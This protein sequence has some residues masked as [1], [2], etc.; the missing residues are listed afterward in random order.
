MSA[1]GRVVTEETS[2][3]NLLAIQEHQCTQKEY[4]RDYLVYSRIPKFPHEWIGK[5]LSKGIQVRG[6]VLSNTVFDL[7]PWLEYS[8]VSLGRHPSVLLERLGRT[9]NY[10]LKFPFGSRSVRVGRP[11]G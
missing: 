9:G 6:L 8:R 2:I 5:L 7:S 3:E 1:A 10:H 4:W 11:K